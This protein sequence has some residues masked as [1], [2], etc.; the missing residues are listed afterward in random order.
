MLAPKAVQL[1]I[2][3]A[4]VL[5]EHQ[6]AGLALHDYL[7]ALR[8]EVK[9]RRSG[10]QIEEESVTSDDAEGSFEEEEEA[11]DEPEPVVEAEEAKEVEEGE[12]VEN[13]GRMEEADL[14]SPEKRLRVAA[15]SLG[16]TVE[17]AV[18]RLFQQQT[19][20][21]SVP[22]QS[23]SRTSSTSPRPISGYIGAL[24][25][26]LEGVVQAEDAAAAKG[27]AGMGWEEL[28]TVF[29]WILP[30][31]ASVPEE[32]KRS[33]GEE[34]K[35][36]GRMK[37]RGKK[38]KGKGSALDDIEQRTKEEL[39]EQLAQLLLRLA[40][41]AFDT[42]LVLSVFASLLI[43]FTS[44]F[45]LVALSRVLPFF[46][47]QLAS[48]LPPLVRTGDVDDSSLERLGALVSLLHL[49]FQ[50]LPPSDALQLFLISR[51]TDAV[52]PLQ[53]SL[54]RLTHLLT[55]TSTSLDP[56]NLSLRVLPAAGDGASVVTVEEA[57]LGVLE[58]CWDFSELEER[59]ERA[60]AADEAGE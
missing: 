13:T 50:A 43:R 4:L 60:E 23:T 32:K 15:S 10:G 39:V 19:S 5:L 47:D 38:R 31:V 49:T 29:E 12:E 51:T 28:G 56:D 35:D 16:A 1:R 24:I 14:V 30:Q 48:L 37:T 21:P 7:K 54:E 17:Q 44:F 45:P 52:R 58:R 42:P 46:L 57:V 3:L 33:D 2:A 20:N 11:R 36:T 6:P 53:L 41:P 18:E 40:T 25:H 9:K 26:A 27:E 8:N 22:S 55:S 34:G 59:E